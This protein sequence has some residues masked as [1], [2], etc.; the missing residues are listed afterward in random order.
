MRWMLGAIGIAAAAVAVLIIRLWNRRDSKKT[1][2]EVSVVAAVQRKEH[3]EDGR[4][5]MEFTE[6]NGEHYRF[7]VPEMVAQ[8]LEVGQQGVL[9][10]CK[11]EFIYFVRKENLISQ[12]E[13]ALRV[14]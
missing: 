8:E 5:V 7:A 12:R 2:G 13:A 1:R 14:S 10:F 9:T 6:L 3:L 11:S 4:P